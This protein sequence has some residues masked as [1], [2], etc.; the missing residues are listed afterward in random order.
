MRKKKQKFY[1]F[2][3][4]DS[5]KFSRIKLK[6]FKKNVRTFLNIIIKNNKEK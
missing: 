1:Y 3:K 5:K 4:K 2:N 6:I